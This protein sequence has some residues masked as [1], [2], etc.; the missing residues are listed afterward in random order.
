MIKEGMG[1]RLS[2]ALIAGVMTA[3]VLNAALGSWWLANRL[4]LPSLSSLP[5]R[6]FVWLAGA[7]RGFYDRPGQFETGLVAANVIVGTSLYAALL[8]AWLGRWRVSLPLAV[9]IAAVECYAV[10]IT[11]WCGAVDGMPNL[12][13]T[14]AAAASLLAIAGIWFA[15]HLLLG[16]AAARDLARRGAVGGRYKLKSADRWVL[17]L[18]LFYVL[19]A[20]LIELPWLLASAELAR[21]G[22]W[23]GALWAFYGRADRGYFD[24]VSGF[25]RGIESFHIFITQ[26]LHIW[27]ICAILQRWAHR[28][29]LQLV[30]GSYVAFSTAVYLAAKHMTGYPLMPQHSTGAFLTLYL[31]NLPW[32]LGNSWIAWQGARGLAVLMAQPETAR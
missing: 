16:G 8:A 23:F 31:A 11:L 30:V 27:L 14:M 5:S 22:G 12:D 29:L 3:G 24:L 21:L 20:F 13:R 17:G 10:L 18:T 26:W 6:V 9:A 2:P 4:A 15:L 7:D 28:F 1:F 25:E 19:A 32:L